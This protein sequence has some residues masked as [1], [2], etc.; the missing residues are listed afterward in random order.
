M[1][2]H[3]FLRGLDTRRSRALR[4]WSLAVS[5]ENTKEAELDSNKDEA[6]RGEEDAA[7]PAAIARRVA[8]LGAD[9]EV[10]ALAREEERKLA[11]RRAANKK[12]KK[13]GLEAAASKKLAKI[14]TR[15]EPRRT[16]AVASDADPLIERTEKFSEWAKKNQKLVQLV[17]VGLLA[18]LVGLGG[19]LHWQS[20]REIDAS[21]TLSKAVETQRAYVGEPPKKSD[22]DDDD[23]P[24]HF[25]TAEDRRTAA[26]KQYKEVQQ[27]FHGT[28]ASILARLSE[29]S[30]LLDGHDADGALAAFGDVKGS[31]LAAADLE[32]K[33]RALEGI[34]FA[35]EL[36]A[37]ANPADKAKH[38]DAA[39]AS[40]KEL[41]TAVGS[42]RG[43]K[44]M[45]L[46]HQAR[47]LMDKGEKDKAKEVLT[48]LKDLLTKG[49]DP[50]A[51]GLPTPPS[52]PYLKEVAMDR[53]RSIDPSAVPSSSH[54]SQAG[55][56]MN[57][58]QE[59]IKKL[60]ENAAKKNAGGNG[61]GH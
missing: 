20:S 46:Y 33:S 22:D 61:A 3:D 39:L 47:A 9:D 37:Q 49:D 53:L 32:V 1:A 56:G 16:V 4:V 40:Y 42:A 8:A 34:G 19:Y 38:L 44:E 51:P 24:Q 31:V 2:W 60:M 5:D 17:G 54:G 58:T 30:L 13:T 15:A 43:L 52:F 14:G 26:L 18:G 23:R 45:S 28:G 12:G 35:Y 11:E 57:L 21:V 27:K 41:E 10:E 7:N 55:G 59:Q 25:K 50:I 36:K 29:G 6:E 48:T